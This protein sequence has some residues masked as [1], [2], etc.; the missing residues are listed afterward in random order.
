MKTIVL[1]SSG[2]PS[3]N[4][5]LVK[6]ADALS[7]AG[8][9]VYVIY[10]FWTHWALE[11]DKELFVSTQW[12]PVLAGGS[13]FQDSRR[14]FFTRLRFK[15]ANLAAKRISFKWGIA[16][17]AKGRASVEM[18]KKAKSIKADLYIAHN[19]AALPVAVKA[20]KYHGAKCGFDAEDFH[21]QEVSDDSNSPNYKLSK[22]I[23]D[24]YLSKCNYITAA[25]PLI[26][27]AYEKLY[28]Q[29]TPIVINNVFEAKYLQPV[30]ANDGGK[31]KLFWFSQTVGQGRGLEDVI[32][33]LHVLNNP[34]IE[35]HLLGNC[36]NE[37]NN[38]LTGLVNNKNI[39]FYFYPPI[40][41][42]K[43][44]QFANQ[45][46]I[47]LALETKTP[48]NRDICLTNK[49]FTY[50]TAGL[51]VIV[52]DTSA[53]KAF[54]EE[55]I[56]LGS[57]YPVGGVEALASKIDTFYRNPDRLDACKTNAHILAGSKHNWENECLTFVNKIKSLV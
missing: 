29:T 12:H 38:Y 32:K 43:I 51:A 16:H 2:Q 36:N 53:Q 8:Y 54:M 34:E 45:F 3:V 14:Y 20:A 37:A 18:L 22:F 11:A 30:Q 24:K 47:G 31:M 46:D 4:P 50:L 9:K 23:E 35:L 10:S 13:P 49:I 42:E 17:I 52:S 57:I 6:E 1:I 44:F 33:A 7:A 56:G 27:K 25:S 19:L 41:P 28:P 21:R 40:P 55:N 5:R 26:A 39:K 48:L 15:A